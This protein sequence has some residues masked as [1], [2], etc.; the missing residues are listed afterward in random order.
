MTCAYR[1]ANLQLGQYAGSLQR[2]ED[3]EVINQLAEMK[4]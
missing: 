4:A 3:C 1:V 2:V